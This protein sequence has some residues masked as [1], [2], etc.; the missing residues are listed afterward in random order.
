M[1]CVSGSFDVFNAVRN[2]WGGAL[3]DKILQRKGTLV[4]RPDSGD[5]VTILEELFKIASE[6]FGV[7]RS[8]SK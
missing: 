5:A 3:R 6:K 7:A 8:C 2:L 1:A 4:I